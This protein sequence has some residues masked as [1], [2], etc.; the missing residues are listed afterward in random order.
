MTPIRR[1]AAASP[2]LALVLILPLLGGCGKKA[3]RLDPPE[4]SGPDAA[5]FPRTY[6][7]PRY[8]PRPSGKGLGDGA[9]AVQPQAPG[10][11][12]LPPV[13]SYPKVMK[14]EDLTNFSPLGQNNSGAGLK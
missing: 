12:A 13:E 4:G 5:L 7:N 8:D 10:G 3:S 9:G 11:A 14:P 6:P 2:F 1:L